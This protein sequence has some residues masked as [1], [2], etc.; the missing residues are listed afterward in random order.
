VKAAAVIRAGYEILRV[1]L[2]VP[3][4]SMKPPAESAVARANPVT[5]EVDR[6]FLKPETLKETVTPAG[7]FLLARLVTVSTELEKEH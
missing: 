1:T 2:L 5:N 7:T 6:G 3:V 4:K